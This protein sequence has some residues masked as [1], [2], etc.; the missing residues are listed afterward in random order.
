MRIVL[1]ASA[2]LSGIDPPEAEE[3]LMPPLVERELG[4]AWL[5]RKLAYLKAVRLTILAPSDE[6]IK[7]VRGAMARTGDDA[8]V[9]GADIQVLAL[10]LETGATILTDDYSIQNLATVLGI[11][12]RPVAQAGIREVFSWGYRCTGCGKVLDRRM[13]ECPVCGAPVRSFRRG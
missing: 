10:A 7:K 8:R 13:D 12:Y 9:S 1:D 5:R 4:H 3:L 6:A 2:L 11:P